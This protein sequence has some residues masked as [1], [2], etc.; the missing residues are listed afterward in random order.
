MGILLTVIIIIIA[1]IVMYI[2]YDK[3][4][5]VFQCKAVKELCSKLET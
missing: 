4:V 1:G 3:A 2:V 5:K